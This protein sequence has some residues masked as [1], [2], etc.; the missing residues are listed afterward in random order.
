MV[1]FKLCSTNAC[2]DAL[3]NAA[4]NRVSTFTKS[5][6]GH[7]HQTTARSALSIRAARTTDTLRFA[8]DLVVGMC[9]YIFPTLLP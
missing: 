4:T 2:S 7:C 5:G 9:I 6:H 3:H 8:M 1:K